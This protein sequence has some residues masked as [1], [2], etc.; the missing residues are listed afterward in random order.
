ML[1]ALWNVMNGQ[2]LNTGTIVIIIT[3]A[4]EKLFNVGHDEATGTAT[5][6]MMGVGGVIALV[7]YIHKLTKTKQVPK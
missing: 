6:I 1:K 4:L 2:K 3:I 5:S 7:G